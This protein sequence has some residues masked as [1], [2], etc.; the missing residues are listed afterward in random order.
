VSVPGDFSTIQAAINATPAGVRRLI[1]V[2]PGTYSGP[3]DFM[4][5]DVVVQ[6]DGPA[7]TVIQG[8]GGQ[9][10]SV[11]RFSGGEPATAGL[12]G[13]TVR[14]GLTGTPIPAAPQFL[15]GGGLFADESAAF[16]R[17]CVF[18]DNFAS[19]GGGVYTRLYTGSFTDCT[20]RQNRSGSFGGGIQFLNSTCDMTDCVVQ[21]NTCE[22]RGGGIHVVNGRHRLTRVN[23]NGN[24][25]TTIMAG[26]SCDNLSDPQARLEFIACS[27]T[28]NAAVVGQGGIGI[29]GNSGS[30]AVTL[31]GTTVCTNVPR[32]NISGPWQDLGGNTVC[33]CL[34]D[35]N[36]DEVVNGEDLG[37]LLGAWGPCG[38]SD[39][40][41]D[42]NDDTVVDGADLG[43][44]LGRWG[45]C[46]S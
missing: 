23:I 12:R 6:G 13:F 45:T 37:I 21:N 10:S 34:A 28:N 15:V 26:V 41:A 35:L 19:Y 29:L 7:N 16:V 11:V 2:A 18:V 36:S 30:T 9:V 24:T 20:F 22:A 8:T 33:L 42:L 32:P 46:P 40:V 43:I 17:D 38:T 3:I 44:L 27:V 4:G 14:G 31:T 5:K 1:A 25:S 39:C